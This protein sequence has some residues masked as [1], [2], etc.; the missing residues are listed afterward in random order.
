MPPA[1]PARRTRATFVVALHTAERH[2]Q[3]WRCSSRGSAEI[4]G[5]RLRGRGVLVAYATTGPQLGRI[6][7]AWLRGKQPPEAS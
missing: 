6:V 1:K 5:V 7:A 3:V 2:V 4:L